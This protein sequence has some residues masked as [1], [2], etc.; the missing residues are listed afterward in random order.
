MSIREIPRIV[1]EWSPVARLAYLIVASLILSALWVEAIAEQVRQNTADIKDL[2][3]SLP[4]ISD[5]VK[6]TRNDVKWL[7]NKLGGPQ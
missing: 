7:K 4:M 2:K 1:K 5:D 3:A 6:E